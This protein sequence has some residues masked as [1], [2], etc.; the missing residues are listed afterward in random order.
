MDNKKRWYNEYKTYLEQI[1]TI[2]ISNG[3]KAYS[4]ENFVAIFYKYSS[5]YIFNLEDG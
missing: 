2:I 3:G 1:N 4:K 5:H